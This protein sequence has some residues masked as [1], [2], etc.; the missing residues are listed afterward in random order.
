MKV[1]YR[2]LC[3]GLAALAL[4]GCGGGG[5]A[6][7]TEATA[8]SEPLAQPKTKP[9]PRR[10]LQHLDL[11]L[12]GLEGP[13]S[14]G[15]IL[16][17]KNGFFAD[18]GLDVAVLTP[19]APVN[20][21]KYVRLGL[22]DLGVAPLPQ[23]V[24]A[25]ERGL[26]IVAVGSVISRPT[27]TMIWLR[28]SGI[29][30]IE[31]L[32]G[33]TIA[34]PGLSFQKYFLERLL[35]R[36]GLTLEDVKVKSVEYGLVPSLVSG[37][38]DA[39]FGGSANI[40]GV[41]LRSRGLHPFITPVGDLG[42]PA[43]DQMVIIA[44]QRRAAKEPKMVRGFMAAVRRGTAAAIANPEAAVDAIA[45]GDEPSH[46][47]SRNDTE[48]EIKATLPLLSKTGEMSPRTARRLVAWM[49]DEGLLQ[50]PLS[51]SSLLTNRDLPES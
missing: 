28:S 30:G 45:E 19:I 37:R 5:G 10:S 14:A 34:I 6:A 32:K 21:V 12:A 15:I 1:Y 9:E 20:S 17:A 35:A 2:L 25:R 13:E 11:T 51:V 50:G 23:V 38:A 48:A 22:D 8:T 36:A 27:A 47:A 26:P 42:L 18:A 29:D 3:L 16:A 31:D 4:A 39:I 44:R 33:K 7:T 24:M 46:E 43:Y 41:E 40:E 49:R